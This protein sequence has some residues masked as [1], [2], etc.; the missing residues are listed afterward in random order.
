LGLV[1]GGSCVRVRPSPRPA[2][3]RF[4]LPPPLPAASQSPP[5]RP[6]T[7][8]PHTH[9][10]PWYRPLYQLVFRPSHASQVCA[11]HSDLLAGFGCQ[12]GILSQQFLES[13]SVKMIDK[14]GKEKPLEFSTLV[15][16]KRLAGGATSPRRFTLSR[17]AA[18][19]NDPLFRVKGEAD[20]PLRRLER[21][22][23]VRKAGMVKF[24]SVSS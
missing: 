21:H 14:Y 2:S 22:S 6:I 9:T 20:T 18:M 23:P 17:A 19:R 10:K 3:S 4:G 15:I 7:P 16:L 12:F 8:P 13:D 24:Q 1:Q 11:S 5:N